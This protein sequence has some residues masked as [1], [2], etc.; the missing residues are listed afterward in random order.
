MN[1]EAYAFVACIGS[2]LVEGA[3]TFAELVRL[4]HRIFETGCEDLCIWQGGRLLEVWRSNGVRLTLN[5]P[6]AVSTNGDHPK[7]AA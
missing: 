3:D 4:L 5:S 2:D 7:P 6:V 1:I